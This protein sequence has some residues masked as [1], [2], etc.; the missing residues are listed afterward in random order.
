MS[1]CPDFET[2]SCVAD[3]AGEAAAARHAER[4]ADCAR[5]VERIHAVGRALRNSAPAG[6]RAAPSPA[7]RARRRAS[8]WQ[9]AAVAAAAA[10]AFGGAWLAGPGPGVSPSLAAEAVDQHLQAFAKG[11]GYEH[12]GADPRDLEAFLAER[13][14][15][16]VAVPAAAHG[17]ILGAR[18]CSLFGEHAAAV[19][20]RDEEV[21][22]TLFVPSPGSRAAE[23]CAES[24]G[25][26]TSAEHGQTVCVVSGPEGPRVL[27][28]RLPAARLGTL[29]AGR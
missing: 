9:V 24:A 28:G 17:Q 2:L 5:V 1:G 20:Y 22:V 10:L 8:P 11:S 14:G 15:R 6:E 19:V 26:C 23:L 21:P 3:G 13:L 12:A 4:C 27:V 7:R 18:R 16:P 29:L 25:K